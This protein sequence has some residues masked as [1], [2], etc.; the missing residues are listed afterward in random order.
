M[1][2]EKQQIMTGFVPT[3]RQMS[4]LDFHKVP[5]ENMSVWL[6]Q[7]EEL[8]Q[9]LSKTSSPLS[10]E[11]RSGL[12]RFLE[13]QCQEVGLGIDDWLSVV[14]LFDLWCE[15]R[16]KGVAVKQLPAA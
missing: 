4:M 14:L 8:R 16:P 3:Y 7:D 9:R 10:K 6:K 12:V 2:W 13:R 1:A 11:M 15:S 5:F